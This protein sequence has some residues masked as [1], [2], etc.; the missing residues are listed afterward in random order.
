MGLLLSALSA[1]EDRTAAK[2]V[3]TEKNRVD[4]IEAG[5][6]RVHIEEYVKGVGKGYKCIEIPKVIEIK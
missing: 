2:R 4:C 6:I 5:G 1:L 3:V